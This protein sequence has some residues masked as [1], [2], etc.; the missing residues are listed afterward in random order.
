MTIRRHWL[1]TAALVAAITLAG[2]AAPPQ[3]QAE[4]HGRVLD[5]TTS[6][7]VRGATVSWT[8]GRPDGQPQFLTGPD[9]QFVLRNVTPGQVTLLASKAGYFAGGYGQRRP[10]GTS[11]PLVLRD[12]ERR[13]DVVLSLWPMSSI[14]GIVF[15]ERG[16]P[17]EGARV[18]V[19][20]ARDV[21]ASPGV[22]APLSSSPI[23]D[24]SGRYTADGLLAGEYVVGITVNYQYDEQAT[25]R[26]GRPVNL[27]PV[28]ATN[29]FM[30]EGHDPSLDL[31]G[32]GGRG[33][34]SLLGLRA[35]PT[36]VIGG[37]RFGYRGTF[38]G[39]ETTSAGAPTI[40]IQAGEERT[41]VDLRLAVHP[42]VT[43]AGTVVAD[44]EVVAGASVLLLSDTVN[45]STKS[46]ADGSFVFPNVPAGNYVLAARK[47]I[48]TDVTIVSAGMRF[49][50]Q[51]LRVGERDL[52]GLEIRIAPGF[53][54]SGTL[55][56]RP[57]LDIADVRLRLEGTGVGTVSQFVSRGDFAL[58]GIEPGHYTLSV[59]HARAGVFIDAIDIGGRNLAGLPLVFETGDLNGVVVHVSDRRASMLGGVLKA[60][61]QPAVNST[62]VLFPVDATSWDAPLLKGELQ[63][64]QVRPTMGEY[65]FNG[66]PRGEYFVAAVDDAWLEDWHTR[67]L[68]SKLSQLATRVTIASGA[69]IRRDFTVAER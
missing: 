58:T 41:G 16:E 52:A 21:P 24:D 34:S 36:I 8:S 50:R 14:S 48:S 44:A 60:D 37:K 5:A 18:F 9:G 33:I 45:A 11:L 20:R 38:Y 64:Q 2:A 69:A 10:Q 63:F 57:D 61:G 40:S 1:Q 4:I 12:A 62:V 29:R 46:R 54:L 30:A 55:T 25:S 67:A 7:P 68:L 26:T 59:D 17:F 66:I 42:S 13:Q 39:G 31:M 19:R 56:A 3:K 47:P 65:R 28:A 53:K 27:G 43:V 51:P 22:P 49:G 6:Q 23:T 15:D 35:P 32:P